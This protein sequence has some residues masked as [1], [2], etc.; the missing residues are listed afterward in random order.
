[1]NFN[2]DFLVQKSR[3]QGE[4]T[5]N[6]KKISTHSSPVDSECFNMH[7]MKQNLLTCYFF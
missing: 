2:T 3:F 7:A 1:M 5:T 6:Q 4:P